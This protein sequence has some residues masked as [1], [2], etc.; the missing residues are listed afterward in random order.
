[1]AGVMVQQSP[2]F[3]SFINRYEE[4]EHD[5]LFNLSLEPKY[6]RTSHGHTL[7]SVWSP[8]K[9]KYS[10]GL[11]DVMAFL[12][13]DGN[14]EKYL[15]GAV[16]AVGAVSAAQLAE[17]SKNVTAYQEAR[18][19]L[20]KSSLIMPDRSSSNLIIHRL[21]QYAARI[22]MNEYRIVE[23]FSTTVD[24]LWLIWLEAERGVRHH[25]ARRKDCEAVSPHIVRLRDHFIRASGATKMRWTGNL[26]FAMLINELGWYVDSNPF[27]R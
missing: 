8:E 5:I 19:E 18:S 12:D 11:L 21:I 25:V 20:L 4:E 3:A 24:I 15:K 27:I 23:V 17:Y 6:K 26:H 22:R 14:S 16:G 2:S 9:L 13:P 7:A 1:M 10:S